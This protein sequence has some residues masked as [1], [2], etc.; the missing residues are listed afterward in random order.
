VRSAF[1]SLQASL[2]REVADAGMQRGDVLA[3]WFGEGDAVTPDFIRAAAVQALDAGDTFYTYNLG[4]PAL[5]QAIAAYLGRLHGPLAPG[6]IAVTSAGISGLMLAAQALLDPGARVVAVTPAWPNITQIPAVLG[7][8]VERFALDWQAGRWVLYT[9]A[10]LAAITPQTKALIVNSP[11][12]PTGWTLERDAM[13]ALLAHCRRL[14]VWILSD[15]AYERLY[16]VDGATTA[17]SFLDLAAP[18]DRV[19]CANTF[20]KAW[21]MTGWRLGW[22]AGPEDFIGQLGKLIEYN[23]SCAPPFVQRAGIAALEQGESLIAD[24]RRRY[25][26]CRDVLVNGLQALPRVE[27][28]APDG[29]MY[30]FLRVHGMT[31]SLAF[32]KRLVAEAG[33]GLAPGAAFGPEGEGFFRW[34]FAASEERLREGVVRLG[35]MLS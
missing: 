20:S 33:L 1:L 8:Q 27:V 24:T 30:V 9:D 32:A 14:G 31:D 13:Q 3:F 6:R 34:C 29:A 35:R 18:E 26:R 12:N 4:L 10:L 22:L 21:S 28:A 2:I 17:P 15:E 7:A 5:R 11:A 23:T 16:Y 25:Q 19:I